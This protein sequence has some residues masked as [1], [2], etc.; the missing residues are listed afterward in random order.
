MIILMIMKI[1]FN[2][3]LR[4]EGCQPKNDFHSQIKC[5]GDR[6]VNALAVIS[7]I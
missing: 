6:S 2:F 7:V 4:I 1:G 5:T 3:K